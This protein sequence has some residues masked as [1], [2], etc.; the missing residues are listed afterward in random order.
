MENAG[1]PPLDNPSKDKKG[2]VPSR[3]QMEAALNNSVT[4]AISEMDAALALDKS[5]FDDGRPIYMLFYS[6]LYG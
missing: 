6:V 3:A 5:A 1:S 2:S 4:D